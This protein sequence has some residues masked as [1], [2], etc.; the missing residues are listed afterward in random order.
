MCL[1]WFVCCLLLCFV[2]C[3]F[4]G[5]KNNSVQP[6]I[7]SFLFFFFSFMQFEMHAMTPREFMNILMGYGG[8]N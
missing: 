5:G 8:W 4:Q 2:S 3:K 7:D 6:Q 1:F